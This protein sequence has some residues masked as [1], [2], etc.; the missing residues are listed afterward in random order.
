MLCRNTFSTLHYIA[1]HCITMLQHSRNVSPSF[2]TL[3]P[4]T[5]YITPYYILLQYI[6]AQCL[7]DQY[8]TDQW[9]TE[10]YLP[11]CFQPSAPEGNSQIMTLG[12][13]SYNFEASYLTSSDEHYFLKKWGI[14]CRFERSITGWKIWQGSSFLRYLLIET[15]QNV[16]WFIS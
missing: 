6:T 10:Q 16:S 7:T 14:P 5:C 9:P 4:N 8:I 3:Q 2:A 12:N 13:N 15:F 11:R 1:L